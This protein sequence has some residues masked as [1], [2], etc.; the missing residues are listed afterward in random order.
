FRMLE[1]MTAFKNYEYNM[2]LVEELYKYIAD[3][4]FDKFVFK[5]A[6]QDVDFSKPWEKIM[7][8]DAVKKYAGYDFNEVKTL[9]QAHK[10]LDEIGYKEK[11][12]VSIG[13]SMVKVF[14]EKVEKYLIQP[15]FVYGHPVETSPL[16]KQMASDPRFVE[17]F[18]VFIGG[19]EGGD[20]W[21][22]LNDPILLYERLK[23]QVDR[24]RGGDE[25][26]HPMDLSFIE[27][28][29]YGMPPTTGLGPGIERLAMMFTESEYID[30]ILYFPLMRP[31]P[32][33]EL[34]KEIYGEEYLVD[35]SKQGPSNKKQDFDNSIVIVLSKEVESWQ[36]TNTIAHIA[37]SIGAQVGY[38]KYNFVDNFDTEDGKIQANSQYGIIVKI[39]NPGQMANLLENVLEKKLPYLAFTQDMID[40]IDDKKLN[41]NTK[42]QKKSE[43]NILGIGMYGDKE[44]LKKL[45]NKFSLYK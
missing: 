25:E 27:S 44:L 43:L 31:E 16:A 5:I 40:F 2:D 45:T 28:M 42:N 30:D 15:T 3:K 1:T 4:V 12:P 26:F 17:R 10:I 32:V 36:M 33:T 29:E 8:I 20:N 7:M 21:T 13:E 6:G 9:D 34:Q 23:E 22:E 39:A 11:K 14:E 19:I 38:D 18:E 24:G 41:E 35:V 37:G